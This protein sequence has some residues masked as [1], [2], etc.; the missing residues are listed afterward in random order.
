[1]A[2]LFEYMWLAR[3]STVDHHNYPIIEPTVQV[4]PYI[5]KA[6]VELLSSVISPMAAFTT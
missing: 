6:S 4:S 3:F 1:M 5:A 2:F